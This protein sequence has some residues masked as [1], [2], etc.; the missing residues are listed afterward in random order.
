ML[1]EH[2]LQQAYEIGIF[3]PRP[4]TKQQAEKDER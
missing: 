4:P 2:I 3:M 1:K